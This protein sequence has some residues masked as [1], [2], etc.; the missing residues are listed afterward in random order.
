MV[1]STHL[2]QRTFIKGMPRR[3]E[4]ERELG[5]AAGRSVMALF[6]NRRIQAGF[7]FYYWWTGPPMRL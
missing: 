6:V 4:A 2:A 5:S 7:Y 3:P 1:S